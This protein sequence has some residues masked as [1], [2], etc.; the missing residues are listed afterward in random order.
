MKIDVLKQLSYE[1]LQ[2]AYASFLKEQNLAKNT[3][4]TSKSDA[5]YLLKYD[6]SIDFW[7]LLL[8]DDFEITAKTHLTATLMRTSSGN[9]NANLSGYM[10]HLRR[11]RKFVFADD[12]TLPPKTANPKAVI[13]KPLSEIPTPCKSEVEY[14]LHQWNQLENYRLQEGALDKLFLEYAPNNLEISDI[15]LKAAT[16]NDFYSTNIFSIFPVAKHIQALNIDQRLRD[17]DIS[18]VDDI[19]DVIINGK[20]RHLYSF[21]TKYCSHHNPDHYPIYDRYVEEVLIYFKKKDHFATF[22]SKDLKDYSRFKSLLIEFQNYYSL[23]EYSLKQLDQY[24][25]QLGKRYFP[26]QYK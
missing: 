19:K 3:I 13:K 22:S 1:E 16:L 12:N 20:T 4:S 14:Y 26:K 24:L 18:L 2:N 21:A 5:F 7:D 8:R 11:F 10:S 17:G 15:L 6:D 23:R 25:W 9:V